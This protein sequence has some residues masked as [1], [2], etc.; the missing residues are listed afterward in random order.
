MRGEREREGNSKERKGGVKLRSS[1]KSFGRSRKEIVDL[2]GGGFGREE[3]EEEEGRQVVGWRR[4]EKREGKK[5]IVGS[6]DQWTCTLQT[7]SDIAGKVRVFTREHSFGSEED[8]E[9]GER[10]GGKRKRG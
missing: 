10:K 6:A 1:T 2:C 7:T 4:R 5:L 3:E 9:Q 8:K